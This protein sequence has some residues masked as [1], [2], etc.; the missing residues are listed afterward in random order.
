[1]TVSPFAGAR[2]A[3]VPMLL[4]AAVFIFASPQYWLRWETRQS[5]VAES[6]YNSD[7]Y[8]STYPAMHYGFGRLAAG[9]LPHWNAEQ[10]CGTPYLADYRNGLFQPVHAVFAYLP[11]GRAMATHAFVCLMLMGIGFVWFARSL[12]VAYIPALIGGLAY[13]FSGASAA[14]VSRPAL[15]AALAWTPFLF[16]ALREWTLRGRFA[17]AVLAGLAGALLILSGANAVTLPMVLLASG[18]A[19]VLFIWPGAPDRPSALR[20]LP[21][22]AV[23]PMVAI[24]L[25]AI[26]WVPT[27]A[28]FRQ[29]AEP[30]DVLWNF[31]I[32]AQ[33]PVTVRE[34]VAQLFAAQPGSLPRVAYVGAVPLLLLSAAVFHRNGRGAMFVFYLAILVLVPLFLWGPEHYPLGFPR[35]ALV[36]PVAFAMAVLACLGVDRLATRRDRSASSAV[37]PA[38]LVTLTSSI[39]LLKIAPAE[40]RGYVIVFFVFM[41]LMVLLRFRWLTVACGVAIALVLAV[42]LRIASSNTYTHPFQNADARFGWH[43]DLLRTAQEESLGGRVLLSARDLDERLPA[44]LGMMGPL[45]MAGG[46]HLP[47]SRTQADWWAVLQENG[48]GP[49]QATPE[50]DSVQLW[51]FMA[52]RAAAIANDGPM[53]TTDLLRVDSGFREVFRTDD[54]GL[55]VNDAALPRGYWVPGWEIADGAAG[56]A[57][58]LQSGVFDPNSTC[59]IERNSPGQEGLIKAD[60]DAAAE[61]GANPLTYRDAACSVEDVSPEEV[62]IRVDAPEQGVTVLSDTYA[63]GWR[64]TLDDVSVETLLVNGSFRGVVTPPG[65]HTI[66]YRYDFAPARVGRMI[67][68]AT[69]GILSILG[70]VALTRGRARSGSS[71]AATR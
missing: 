17:H 4:L 68:L 47:L 40:M 49:V 33:V 38:A 32:A 26:Q 16:W 30:W 22:L 58:L 45:H 44:N 70:L 14:A 27:L 19:L 51:D 37:W 18:F 71:K 64:A 54:T 39:V 8:Q 3:F 59:V 28:W 5:S 34:L 52:V 23:I 10:L 53:T 62:V 21:G 65:A 7:L 6:Y 1:M 36:Y 43:E 15:A 67:S 42:D 24:G 50:I 69:A 60:G 20:R 35:A 56:V 41:L 48:A 63:I 25:S 31:T 57:A 12:S 29:L 13:A 46:A 66:R 9:E 55:L 2:Y 11:T 61:N